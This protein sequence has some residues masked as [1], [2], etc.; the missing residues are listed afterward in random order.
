MINGKISARSRTRRLLRPSTRGE[1]RQNTVSLARTKS[2][3]REGGKR[4]GEKSKK[5]GHSVQ[6]IKWKVVGAHLRS[7][8]KDFAL[9]RSKQRRRKRNEVTHPCRG[10]DSTHLTGVFVILIWTSTVGRLK[11]RQP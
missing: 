2:K 6:A 7:G 5:G 10:K 1:G 9:A 4:W 11:K 8:K 3:I